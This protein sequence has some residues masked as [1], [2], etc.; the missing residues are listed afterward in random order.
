MSDGMILW[1]PSDSGTLQWASDTPIP[2]T[3]EDMLV[4]RDPMWGG[5]KFMDTEYISY[6][7]HNKLV[8]PEWTVDILNNQ[9]IA[10]RMIE[11]TTNAE[12]TSDLDVTL[13]TGF[14]DVT[15][16]HL[17][18]GIERFLITDINNPAASA[19]AQSEI[20]VMWDNAHASSVGDPEG[21]AACD[22]PGPEGIG[23]ASAEFNH[24]PGG[25]NILCMDGHVEFVKYPTTGAMWPLNQ[26]SVYYSGW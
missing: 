5:G 22:L 25:S 3:T 12:A 24:V 17:R 2:E 14:G 18:E 16:M 20:P 26:T 13:P 7:Y 10:C 19:K 9:M 15:L 23:V 6:S 21:P 1:C 8:K 11:S 4:D